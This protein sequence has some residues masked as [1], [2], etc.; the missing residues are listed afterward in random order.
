MTSNLLANMKQTICELITDLKENVFTLPND[1]SDLAMVEF[2]FSCMSERDLMQ[3]VIENIIP[4]ATQIRAQDIRFFITQKHKIFE[5]LPDDKVEHFEK[6]IVSPEE[7][8]GMADSDRT[9]IWSYFSTIVK[10]AEEYKKKA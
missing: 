4:F 8:G 10:I 9:I 3:H 5:G 6:L 7:N 2:F 1:Q